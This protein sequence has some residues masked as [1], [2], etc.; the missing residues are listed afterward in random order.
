MSN[1]HVI[2][3]DGLLPDYDTIVLIL[4]EKFG[5]GGVV[6]DVKLATT[7]DI[8]VATAILIS[9]TDGFGK[10]V[11]QYWQVIQPAE[12]PSHEIGNN[13]AKYKNVLGTNVGLTAALAWCEVPR[14]NRYELM[15][16]RI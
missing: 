3:P 9:H 16:E 8:G 4:I 2:K 13:T 12:V 6:G 14:S 7:T 10:K 5:N 15:K 11:P 1:W